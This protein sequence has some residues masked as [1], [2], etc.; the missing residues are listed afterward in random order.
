[1]RI[2]KELGLALVYPV[3]LT[4]GVTDFNDLRN[5]VGDKECLKQLN[6]QVKYSAT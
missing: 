3:S 6:L 5:E 2:A 4:S 1:M